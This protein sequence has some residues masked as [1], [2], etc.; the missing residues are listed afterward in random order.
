MNKLIA[1]LFFISIAYFP[2]SGEESYCFR[3]YLKDKGATGHTLEKPEE[4]LS[5]RAIER[6]LKTGKELTESDLPISASYLHTLE[7]TGVALITKS[8]WLSTVVVSSPD[9]LIA[10]RLRE[11]SFVDDV[12]LVWKGN[13]APKKEDNS[14]EIDTTRFSPSDTPLSD[15]YGYAQK[16]IEM[17]HGDHLHEAG[18][19][20]SGIHIAV[21]DAGFTHV[22]RISAF[23]SLRIGGTYN[24][25]APGQSVFQGDDHGT[26][27]LSCLA[28]NQPGIMVGTAPHATYW[29][30]RSEDS[31][32]EFPIEEDYWA[33]AVEYA[34]SIGIDLI[35]SS[36]GYF[37]FDAEE[38]SY[39]QELLDG[40]T[41]FISKAAAM[42]A[43]KGML[44]VCSAGNEGGNHWEK[45]TFP[46]DAADI[47][48]VGSIT[49]K[50]E[51][52][53]FSSTGFTADYRIKPD[54]TA[55]GTGCCVID[56][57]GQIR[58]ANGTS[59]STPVVAGLAACLWQAIPELT[60]VRLIAL[61]QTTASQ[62]KRPDAEKGYGI[63]DLNKAHKKG[64]NDDY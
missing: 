55:L 11:Y 16:Q 17:L 6:R 8:K 2:L 10:G 63:P 1:F 30:L 24:F 33:A 48:T 22:D 19:T 42:A 35:T 44:V 54:V 28:A 46:S 18:Y 15:H 29:L 43:E 39:T 57:Q 52:S 9:S 38:M 59:Y 5:A 27:V 61:L 51:K 31:S 3:V 53:S 4:F 14:E 45:I 47:L 60:P 21:I 20:G 25:V 49:Q 56:E 34:D 62:Y 58:Y 13:L 40:K 12:K 32:T 36:L 50:K 26:R 7:Q 64:K 23:D 41:A 37:S